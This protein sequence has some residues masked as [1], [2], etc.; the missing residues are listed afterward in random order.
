MN[1][2]F[3]VMSFAQ[4]NSEGTLNKA[5]YLALEEDGAGSTVITNES[6]LRHLMQILKAK[7]EIL[8]Q[9]LF[10]CTAQV[11]NSVPVFVR[12]KQRIEYPKT[13]LQI[14]SDRA[15]ELFGLE[16]YSEYKGIST[17]DFLIKVD[18]AD[19]DPQKSMIKVVEATIDLKNRLTD[20]EKIK[21]YLDL[22]GGLRIS[23]MILMIVSRLLE[24][25]P[26]IEVQEVICSEL[27][28]NNREKGIISSHTDTYELLDMVAGINEFANYG[29]T[30]TLKKYVARNGSTSVETL[31]AAMTDFSEKIQLCRYGEFK[32]SILRL[33]EAICKFKK[34]EGEL[35]LTHNMF[36]V[37]L[38]PLEDKY[39]PLF[40]NN[41][42]TIDYDLKLIRWC[43]SNNYLQQAI[44]LV[45][46]R[47]P[48]I[49]F[50]A[51]N[52]LLT[53]AEDKFESLIAEINENKEKNSLEL[54]PED[55][56]IAERQTLNKYFWLLVRHRAKG[57]LLPQ[58]EDF[59][60]KLNS[61]ITTAIEQKKEAGVYEKL[62][63]NIERAARKSNVQMPSDSDI[64]RLYSQISKAR[65]YNKTQTDKEKWIKSIDGITINKNADDV[66]NFYSTKTLLEKNLIE[67]NKPMER[68]LEL[69]LLYYE[70]QVERNDS[71]HAN[72][73][74]NKISYRSLYDKIDALL[75]GLEG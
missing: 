54:L 3:S 45:T 2:L 16:Y 60:K 22:S 74:Q 59:K 65:E 10:L 72:D 55:K 23:N 47:C 61:F 6:G 28:N 13:H 30:G 70:I 32:E 21:L 34:L 17:K 67:S 64:E 20:G 44:T 14:F 41:M 75:T 48:M 26:E 62:S 11:E 49:M 42:D 4:T 19:S 37:F 38:E 31:V 5:K 50:K 15:E 25:F 40:D 58:Y 57:I 35:G 56:I 12:D 43:L 18:Y 9:Y 29:S 52:P 68:V 63:A 8:D 73:K 39:Q 27:P 7:G 66:G 51:S 1:V 24:Y 69:L 71:N 46:E 36:K 53:I 33:N